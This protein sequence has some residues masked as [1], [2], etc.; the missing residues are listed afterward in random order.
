M[1]EV[2]LLTDFLCLKYNLY[3][4]NGLFVHEK[5]T[6]T[7]FG[8]LLSFFTTNSYHQLHQSRTEH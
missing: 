1:F 3:N 8:A 6:L 5:L 2:T 7:V 4:L